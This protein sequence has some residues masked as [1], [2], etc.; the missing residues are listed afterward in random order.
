MTDVDT[1]CTQLFNYHGSGAGAEEN[2]GAGDDE[3]IFGA[4][5]AAQL[6]GHFIFPFIEKLAL[7]SSLTHGCG[8]CQL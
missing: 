8:I 2:H 6:Q 4:V 1:Q 5:E 7:P 3:V